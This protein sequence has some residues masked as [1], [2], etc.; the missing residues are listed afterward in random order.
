[1][2]MPSCD[3]FDED[4]EWFG[5]A[6]CPGKA[7]IKE[8]TKACSLRNSFVLAPCLFVVSIC[9]VGN[10]VLLSAEM[11]RSHLAQRN[12]Y[13]SP[14][15][16]CYPRKCSPSTL[17]RSVD[18]L[19]ECVEVQAWSSQFCRVS[20]MLQRNVSYGLVDKSPSDFGKR[21]NIQFVR[22]YAHVSEFL[23]NAAHHTLPQRI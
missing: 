10:L 6:H 19:S 23:P 13:S 14:G 5:K 22:R 17:A 20:S 18:Q 16:R 1:M 11:R 2:P 8:A 7:R 12:D 4:K 9:C 3:R 15:V 21:Y